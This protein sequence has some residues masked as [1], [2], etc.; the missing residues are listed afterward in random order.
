MFAWVPLLLACGGAA[1]TDAP[2]ASSPPATEAAPAAPTAATPAAAPSGGVPA[3]HDPSIY[4]DKWLVI[5]ASNKTPGQVPANIGKLPPALKPASLNSSRFKGLMPCY[6]IV[7]A[8]PPADKAAALAAVKQLKGLGVDSYAK[9]AGKYVK[10]DARVDAFCAGAEPVT[11]CPQSVRFARAVGG[12]SF[13]QVGLSPVEAERALAGIAAAKP[14]DEQKQAWTSKLAAQNLGGLSVGDAFTVAGTAGAS[15]AC[16]VTGFVALTHGLPHF[17]WYEM[18]DPKKP[19]CGDPEVWAQLDCALPSDGLASPAGGAQATMPEPKE[20]DATPF[21]AALQGSGVWSKI[22]AE[23]EESAQLQGEAL[24]ASH[25][26]LEAQVG[27]R[28][29]VLVVSTLETRDGNDYCGADDVHRRLAGVVDA[30]SKEVVWP[31]QLVEGHQDPALVALPDG[32]VGLSHGVFPSGRTVI[33][34]HGGATCTDEVA[35]C[36]CPC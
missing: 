1:P 9:P 31:Y 18:G 26:A 14:I 32:G 24:K 6:E 4:A 25:T 12:Q 36:D 3:A 5:L 15:T 30:G 21:V 8:G 16:K 33:F 10:S 27:G 23:A 11:T 29:L 20:V 28:A 7:V 13:L 22:H 34:A 19:G 2:P 35:Y 17:G